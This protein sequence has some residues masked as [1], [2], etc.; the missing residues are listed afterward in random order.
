M[1]PGRQALDDNEDKLD[2]ALLS[3]V[4]AWMRKCK[5]DG[6]TDVYMLLQQLLQKYAA[7]V[8]VKGA[9]PG[10]KVEAALNEVPRRPCC[11]RP[12]ATCHA[13]SFTRFQCFVFPF[14]LPPQ[15]S[16]RSRLLNPWYRLDFWHQ[17]YGYDSNPACS[18]LID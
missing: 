15:R 1:G 7:R 8:L 12:G 4:F 10:D 3:N 16:S 2:E 18:L 17:L 5:D 6:L 11:C 14:L 13:L 9:P